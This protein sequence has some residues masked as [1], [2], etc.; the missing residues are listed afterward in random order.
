MLNETIKELLGVLCAEQKN[1]TKECETMDELASFA[2]EEGLELPDE[3]LD[4]VVGGSDCP[5]PSAE[6]AP[7][8]IDIFSIKYSPEGDIIS[9]G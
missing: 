2:V 9:I 5:T 1:R 3:I 8:P 7:D 4:S 6:T